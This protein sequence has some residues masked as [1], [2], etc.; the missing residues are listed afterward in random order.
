[1]LGA[2]RA[3]RGLARAF[4]EGGVEVV[5]VHGRRGF[6][7]GPITVSAGAIP[8]TVRN[9]NVVLVTVQ[10]GQLPAALA[11]LRAAPLAPGTVVLHASGSASPRDAMRQIRA[12]G[13]P[14]GTFHP[15]V[16]IPDPDHAP[17]L[18]RGAWVGVEGDPEAVRAAEELAVRTGSRVLPIPKEGRAAYHAAAVMA[19]NFPTV[20]AGLATTLMH[21]VGVEEATARAAV[22]H[23]MRAAVTNLAD[24][25]PDAALTG[26]ISRG[27][28]DTVASHLDVLAATPQLDDVY[29]A[30]SRAAIPLAAAQGTDPA[31][32]ARIAELLRAQPVPFT[33]VD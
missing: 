30:L 24:A 11:E 29:R 18:L 21:R 8:A 16:P 20:L 10:D 1:V 33:S 5:G 19:S 26:P 13:N 32:L 27:D 12:Q 17:A 3:G 4:R 15:L 25:E 14:M 31:A 23:L 28:V 6:V 7:D 22:R 9:A 2:G